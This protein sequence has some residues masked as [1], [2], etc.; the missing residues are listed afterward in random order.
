MR[1]G[2]HPLG[3]D[4]PLRVPA[5]SYQQGEDP[6]YIP[7]SVCHAPCDRATFFCTSGPRPRERRFRSIRF[8]ACTAF[9]AMG[10]SYKG[11]VHS[12]VG[13]TPL[14]D[15]QG[16]LPLLVGPAAKPPRA[17]QAREAAMGRSYRGGG[18]VIRCENR[19]R[20]CR[21]GPRPLKRRFRS[22]RLL[23]LTAFGAMGP[24]YL[25]SDTAERLF[26]AGT[27]FPRGSPL[28]DFALQGHLGESQ[29]PG[30]ASYSH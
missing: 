12:Q 21:S 27:V 14:G 15:I 7:P 29:V 10:R 16:A 19:S 18:C 2:R 30:A 1:G 17:A 28:A 11:T 6:V 5:R 3:P 20:C 9:A 24:S 8:P 13:G 26:L 25:T 23:S 4:G 22:K